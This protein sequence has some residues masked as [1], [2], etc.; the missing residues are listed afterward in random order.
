[1][2]SNEKLYKANHI[3]DVYLRTTQSGLQPAEKLC[4]DRVPESARG[5]ILDIGIGV[6]RTTPPLRRMFKRY[7]GV[8]Y[9]APMIE[10][11]KKTFPGVD[12][13]VMDAR[14]LVL[15]EKFDCAMFSF[16]G[17]S[18]VSYEDRLT[19]LRSVANVLTPGGYF[20]YS[21]HNLHHNRTTVWMNSF[22][23]RELFKPMERMR[24]IPNRFRNFKGQYIDHERGFA[25]VNDAGLGFGLL[26]TYVDMEREFEVLRGLGFTIEMVIGNRKDAPGYDAEDNWVYIVARKN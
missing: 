4:F 1:M 3:V 24:F 6:G 9:S 18:S 11:A 14:Y 2:P 13:R 10:A 8:D 15:D 22:W 19:I 23:V 5:S 17:I 21:G 7:V 26:N 25:Y 12:F 20:V 16:N